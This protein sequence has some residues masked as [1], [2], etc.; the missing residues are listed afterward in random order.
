MNKRLLT[1][2]AAALLVLAVACNSESPAR[3]SAPQKVDLASLRAQCRFGGKIAF[4]SDMTG[5]NEIYVLTADNLRRLTDTPWSDEYPKWSPD[6]NR[7]AFSANPHGKFQIFVMNA[8]GTG[9]KQVSH[10]AFEAIEEAW[11]PDGKKIAYTEQRKAGL[12]KSFTLYSVDLETGAEKKILPDF[13]NSSSLPEFS[14]TAPLMAFTGKKLLGW[15]VYIH[16]FATGTT[17]VLTSGGGACRPNFSPDG[18]RIAFVSSAADKKADIWLINPDGRDKM[19]LTD[20]PDTFDYY[21]SWSPD[22]RFI[23]FA[24]GTRHYPYQG[25]WSL[26]IVE[27]ATKKSRPLFASGARD[28]FPDWR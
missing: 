20:L 1:A 3:D 14:P 5:N 2:A 11:Y 10:S 9:L 18:R 19:R 26:A 25:Q 22:G 6:G 21:P 4:Q 28:V 8:D 24:S 12:R 23:V 16:D 15:G 13:R 7:I 17:R 27:V